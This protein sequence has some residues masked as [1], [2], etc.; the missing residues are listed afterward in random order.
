MIVERAGWPLW[1]GEAEGDAA[2]LLRSMAEEA[3][4]FGRAE[5]SL[6]PVSTE[7]RLARRPFAVVRSGSGWPME[8]TEFVAIGIAEISQIRLTTKSWRIFD[9]RSAIRDTGFMPS[10]GLFW[11]CHRQT[12]R[13]SVGVSGRFAIDGLAHHEH[14]TVV[15]VAQ[16][17]LGVLLPRAVSK[18]L[19]S[20]VEVKFLRPSGGLEQAVADSARGRSLARTERP[21][22]PSAQRGRI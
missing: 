3:P 21:S 20:A 15:G 18:M 8:R 7:G 13:A 22:G 1:L 6:L 5:A 12:D 17:S 14:A 10:S 16:A 2:E 11:A 9:G 19:L 4:I